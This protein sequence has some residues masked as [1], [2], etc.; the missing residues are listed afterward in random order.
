LLLPSA[1]RYLL[2]N[3]NTRFWPFLAK[4]VLFDEKNEPLFSA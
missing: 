4:T 1:H 2:V 3:R